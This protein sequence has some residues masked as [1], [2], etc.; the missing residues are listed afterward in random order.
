MPP[1][2]DKAPE[3]SLAGLLPAAGD[4]GRLGRP[5]QLVR[6]GEE[7]L[8]RKA[9]G[10]LLQRAAPVIVVTGAA[11]PEV[12]AELAGMAVTMAHNPAWRNGLGGSIA[13]AMKAV[14][15]NA[16]GVLVLLCDQWRIGRDDLEI[17]DQAW[18]ADP[19]RIVAAS[20]EGQAGAPAIFPRRLFG[21]LRVLEGR[22]GA[23]GLIA[24]H[25]GVRV[26]L[27]NAAQDLDT[28]EDLEEL[29]R[30]AHR[31]GPP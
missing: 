5:K 9:A 27:P 12:S 16:D 15:G 19:S 10:L 30:W 6:L 13:V 24:R 8:V 3:L 18:R 26:T 31:S 29:R 4:A 22:R 14:P 20:W 25:R 1:R 28:R 7:S 23:Q 2:P 21:E 11:A 17:L